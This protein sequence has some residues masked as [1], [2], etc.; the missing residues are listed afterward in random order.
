MAL[1]VVTADGLAAVTMRTVSSLL[2]VTPMALYHHVG[3]KEALVALVSDAVVARV[4]PPSED[5]TWDAWMA[6]Y[7]DA[8]WDHVHRYPD[9]GRF[10]LEH[11]STPAGA[12]IRRRTVSV[13]IRD[14]FTERDALLA[15][16]TFHTHLLGRLAISTRFAQ[17]QRD[18]E[19]PWGAHG[20][21]VDD[22]RR[23]GLDTIVAGLRAVHNDLTR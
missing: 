7:H 1:T 6:A 20:L 5:L 2:G 15:S 9:V 21:S 13:L 17:R 8:L 10:L 11:P 3:D 14:G 23:H 18:D 4:P 22:Y 12:E 19:P 16:S